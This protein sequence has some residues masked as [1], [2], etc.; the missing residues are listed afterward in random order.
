MGTIISLFNQKGGVSKT[1]TT[2]NLASCLKVKGKSVLVVD[3][4]PQ[5]NSTNSFGV[6]DENL[7]LSVYDLLQEKAQETPDKKI[8]KERILEFIQKTSYGVD[9]LPSDITRITGRGE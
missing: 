2:T 1:T 6:D 5:A 9:L 8:K 3:F 7:E 4:D